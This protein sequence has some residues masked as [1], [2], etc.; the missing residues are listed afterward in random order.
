M[1]P[2]VYAYKKPGYT[3]VSPLPVVCFAIVQLAGVPIPAMWQLGRD[4]SHVSAGFENPRD[5]GFVD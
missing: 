2:F 4:T 3:F 1:S 5:G